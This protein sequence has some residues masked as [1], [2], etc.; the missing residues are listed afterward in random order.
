MASINFEKDWIIDFD[1]GH[2]LTEDESN[3]SS[4]NN[5]TGNH[6]IVTAYGGDSE[7]AINSGYHVPR[8]KKNLFSVA[9]VVDFGNYLLFR[10][11]GV[12]FLR[13]LKKVEA[14][15]VH[16]GK[17]V[18]DLFVLFASNSYVQ[19]MSSNDNTSVWHAR[20]GHLHMNKLKVMVQKSLVKDFLNLKFFDNGG[21]C[22][23]CQ[24]G[25]A[26]RFP[27]DR[28]SSK[29]KAPLERI[30]SE[31]YRRI[32][33]ASYYGFHYMLSQRIR[34]KLS[35]DDTPLQNRIA[36]RKIRHLVETC[37]SWLHVKR[38]SKALWVE[39][40]SPIDDNEPSCFDDAKG[41]KDWNKAMD[42]EMAD[43]EQNETWTLVPK[44]A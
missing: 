38:L 19:K 35:C 7:I 8:V 25:K 6:A 33:I 15:V 14:D 40:M 42:E 22:E 13:N 41:R 16:S 9:N 29:S 20:L 5:N 31:L 11:K 1:C 44:P 43:L 12:K 37:K 26:H 4:F 39:G 21:V 32:R 18:K 24:Y 27:F 36:K 17:R 23:G 3:F 34:R 30:H 10:P 28:S 2:H